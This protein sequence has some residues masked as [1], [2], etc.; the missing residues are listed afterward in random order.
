MSE[1]VLQLSVILYF[2]LIYTFVSF[3]LFCL[4]YFHYELRLLVFF[5]LIVLT[6]RLD[7]FNI[8]TFSFYGLTFT[9]YQVRL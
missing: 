1:K 7:I 2:L 6:I 8:K 3:S 9:V 5:N 4:F